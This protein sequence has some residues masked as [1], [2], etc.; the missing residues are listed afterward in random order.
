[1]KAPS[2]A[3]YEKPAR[4]KNK[5][6]SPAVSTTSCSTQVLAAPY[7][8]V[9]TIDLVITFL[10][11][12]TILTSSSFTPPLVVGSLTSSLSPLRVIVGTTAFVEPTLASTFFGVGLA[13]AVGVGVA[14]ALRVGVA[15]GVGVIKESTS[16][17]FGETTSCLV[18]CLGKVF[19]ERT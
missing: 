9:Q 7:T 14:R 6:S 5:M 12:A 13:V 18:T 10:G 16:S 2:P 15:V 3:R 1:M 8:G 4:L 11:L 17:S 19:L